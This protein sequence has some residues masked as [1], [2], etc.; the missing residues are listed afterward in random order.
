MLIIVSGRYTFPDHVS[1]VEGGGYHEFGYITRSYS[2]LPFVIF[3][4]ACPAYEGN[5]FLS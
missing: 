1:E 5:I 4:Y 2:S 3:D